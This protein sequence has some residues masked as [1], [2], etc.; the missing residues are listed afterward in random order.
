MNKDYTITKSR[1]KKLKRVS[2]FVIF[3]FTIITALA[4]QKAKNIKTHYGFEQFQPKNH[5][6]LNDD[7]S[8]KKEFKIKKLS[9]YTFV[10]SLPQKTSQSWLNLKQLTHIQNITGY[11]ES[12]ETTDSILS[13]ANVDTAYTEEDS[14]SIGSY[15]E[16]S[17]LNNENQWTLKDP[18]ISPQ[19]ISQDAKHTSIIVT[20]KNISVQK[21]ENMANQIRAFINKE[22]PYAQLQIG[23]PA[24][25]KT[26][27]TQLLSK[28]LSLFVALSLLGALLILKL[29]FRGFVAP[30]IS[31][32]IIA[33]G[34]I[35]V[36]GFMSI[37][38]FPFTIL[39]ST[40]PILITIT[41][42]AISTHT[43]IKISDVFY[44][45]PVQD[46]EAKFKSI[47]YTLKSLTVPHLLTALTTSVGFSTLLTAKVPMISSYGLTVSLGVLV[48]CLGTLIL[49]PNLMIIFPI[50]KTKK[51]SLGISSYA[52][53]II[54]NHKSLTTGIVT[55]CFG[56]LLIGTQLNWTAL[57]FNDLPKNN[58]SRKT[59]EFISE[60]LGGAIPLEVMI[61]T[62]NKNYWKSHKNLKTLDTL[63]L[64]L[65]AN[66][67]I[68][69]IVSITDFIKAPQELKNIPHSDAGI[70]ESYFMYSMADVNPIPHFANKNFS[71]S[72]LHI[73]LADL[74]DNKM[75]LVIS[76]IKST[77]HKNFK[78]VDVKFGGLAATAHP[79]NREISK[80]MMY[81]FFQALFLV[82]ILLSVVFKSIRW[83]LVA[84]IPNIVPPTILLGF[85][86][87]TQTPIKPG[88]AIIFAISLGIAFDNTVY[89]LGQLR[90]S[91]KKDSE[92]DIKKLLMEE[93][94][95]CLI[96]S[97]SLVAGFSVFLFSFF[98]MNKTFGAFM[99]L[100]LI[101]GLV[102]DLVLLP[103]FLARF[104][105]I[106]S[107]HS[108][109][110]FKPR[111]ALNSFFILVVALSLFIPT[112]A[113]AKSLSAKQILDKVEKVTSIPQ[114]TAFL[115][116]TITNSD[117]EV[118]K[119]VLVIKRKNT[120][121]EQ[122]A[123]IRINE[124]KDLEGLGVLTI[125]KDDKEQQWLY[126]PSTEKTRRILSGN[127][128]SRFLD[129]DLSYEDLSLSTY[130]SFKNT[131]QKKLKNNTVI[132]ESVAKN[133]IGTSYSK[134]K[135]WI[136]IKNFKILKSEYF[137]KKGKLVKKM[138][139]SKYK[140]HKKRYFRARLITVH[141][142]KRKSKTVL[143]L[144]KLSL[145]PIQDK[146]IS[147]DALEDF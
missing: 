144:K 81:G 11:I 116:M 112:Q 63:V 40:V 146:D 49:L 111:L 119:R 3:L 69:S 27:V 58:E 100:S 22:V 14:F 107:N 85:L 130:K 56:F 1:Q 77:I 132:I 126:L 84:I 65:R 43:M 35:L 51:W 134:I 31:L 79:L 82:F 24:A 53:F 38:S 91:L 47:V 138:S 106:L 78:N 76:N 101:A 95:P 50:P 131:I 59:T 89:I 122:K 142:L 8:L 7:V 80:T 61:D 52:Q 18:L 135:S 110:G 15:Y 28:E 109:I 2:V 114:E 97:L 108:P 72:R 88:I 29:T 133:K 102:G 83:S 104:P 127:K 17:Q 115:E 39:S 13:L 71:A 20:L 128:K 5:K 121:N 54:K 16:I 23:G 137:D 48:G 25:I 99:L 60:N 44:S 75:G 74:P 4:F 12:L 45:S 21:N 124:P 68:K 143:K 93:T 37:M 67:S 62:N 32:I 125:N 94:K 42:V 64:S 117:N 33:G 98:E 41:I 147:L 19:L 46:F 96:S 66:P 26:Q 30:L 6:I 120:K 87:I 34:N 92:V 123:L 55:V 36:L 9:P 139:F 70:S 113:I 10:L 73:K 118:Q 145:K 90:Q 141:D 105:K 86:A 57:L 103:A 136:N 140:K 129:S